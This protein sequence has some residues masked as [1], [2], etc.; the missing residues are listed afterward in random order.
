MITPGELQVTAAGAYEHV[1]NEIAPLFTRDSGVSVRLSVAN[2]AGVIARIEAKEPAD[3]V[4]TSAAGIAHLVAANLADADTQA[5]IARVGLGI[6]V[7]PELP[8]PGLETAEAV[9]IALV[10]ATRVA[11]ID[12]RGGGTSG[13]LIATLFERLGIAREMSERGV[14]SKTGKDVVRAVASGE[15][16]VGLTQATELIGAK[17]AR[18]AGFLAPDVQVVSVYSAAVSAFAAAPDAASSYIRFLKSP[19]GIER[20]RHAGWDA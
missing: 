3:V 14:L 6:A 2:A 1:L 10:S 16:T 11:F 12:P 4:L 13:P 20:F 8:L 15:A 5:E 7:R 17:G 19:A 18:F 9:R